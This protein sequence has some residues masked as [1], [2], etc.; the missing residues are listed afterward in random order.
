MTRPWG[1]MPLYSMRDPAMKKWCG[2]MTRLGGGRLS[3]FGEDFFSWLGWEITVVD[4]YAYAGVDFRGDV[5]MIL[6]DGEYFDDDLGDFF[7]IFHFLVF[8]K[9]LI[10]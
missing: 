9:Y 4:D 10:F 7:N 5:D 3:E 1:S 8:L 2:M 6:P